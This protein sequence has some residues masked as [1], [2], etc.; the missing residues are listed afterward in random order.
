MTVAEL[1]QRLQAF[2]PNAQVITLTGDVLLDAH[3]IESVDYDV[4]VM[5]VCVPY[6]SGSCRCPDSWETGK[7]V[8]HDVD[9]I[10]GLL[11]Q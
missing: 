7:H 10:V 4:E 3:H 9:C 8:N 6:D 1:R 2:P 5:L 11:T